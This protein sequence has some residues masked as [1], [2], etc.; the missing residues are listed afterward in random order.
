[1]EK[2]NTHQE[3]QNI[4]NNDCKN[5][6]TNQEKIRLA[7]VTFPLIEMQKQ[8]GQKMDPKLVM[9][10]WEIKFAHR[11]T[12]DQLLFALDK[13]SDLNS[14]FPAPSDI[15]KVLNPE[16]PKITEAQFVAAQKWQERNGFSE[17]T[18]AAD[19]IKKYKEQTEE[20]QEIFAIECK[21][22]QE[23][24]SG[25]VKKITNNSQKEGAKCP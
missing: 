23:I 1:M 14:D 21:E 10:G 7:A 20:K 8:Y 24:V 4:T 12:V 11:Y 13:Y 17:Y 3:P 2:E 18:D 6:W 22:I 16:K 15:V 9:Q 25:C 5:G 19:T